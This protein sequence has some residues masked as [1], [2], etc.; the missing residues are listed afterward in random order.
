MKDLA[1]YVSGAWQAGDGEAHTLYN[2]T[3]EEAVARTS[4]RG[5]DMKATL[6]FAREHGGPALRA[7]SFKERGALI[8]GV[9]KAIHAHREE[10]LDLAV[11]NGGNTRGDA[12]FDVDGAAGTLGYYAKLAESLGDATIL[13]DGDP[14]QLSKSPRL[15][16][17]HYYLPLR[18]AAVLINAFNFP[19]WG[20]AEKAAVAWLAGMPVVTKPATSTAVVAARLVEIIVEKNLLPKGALS[21][22]SGS[23]GDLIDHLGSQDVLAFTGSSDTGASLR[24]KPNVIRHNVRVNIEADSLN[25]AVLGPDVTPDSDVYALFLRE[26]VKDIT[27][28]A[29]QKCTAIRRVFVAKARI[30]DVLRDLSEALAQIKVGNPDL[31]EV[32]MGP[33]ATTQQL[34]DV[35]AGMARLSGACTKAFGELGRGKLVGVTDKGYFLSPVLFTSDDAAVA[36][37]HD[38]EVFGP[39]ATVLPYDGTA[40]G[41]GPL[42]ARGG[43]GLVSSV[44]SDDDAFTRACVMELAPFHGRLHLGSSKVAEH[45]PGP[46]TVLPQLVHGGPGRAGGGEELGGTRSL[47]FYMQRTA[48]QGYAPLIERLAQP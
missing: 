26:V 11:Q 6:A 25:S 28:K 17:R 39:C 32:N 15:V 23:A 43:G 14:A 7:L 10:L 33:L 29:G 24:A 21:F 34:C 30:G 45:S 46:G 47:R 20:F 2:P 37:V 35:K 22:L 12:K 41:V 4:T 44:Y 18:G 16:G 13:A 3:T 38:H 40:A 31:K 5:V 27:Q 1:S 42:V 36:A 19:A 8:D 9:A 48:V